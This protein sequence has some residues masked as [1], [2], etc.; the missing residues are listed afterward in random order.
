MVG[1]PGEALSNM[2]PPTLA[3]L[4]L[5]VLQAGVVLLAASRLESLAD[6]RVMTWLRANAMTLFAV[7]SVAYALF[8]AAWVVV[9]GGHPIDHT[10][11]GWWLERPLFLL[12]PGLVLAALLGLARAVRRPAAA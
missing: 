7:H 12:G 8:Y 5:S 6:T 1:V 9:A 11:T 10:S 3:V 2:G 4:A